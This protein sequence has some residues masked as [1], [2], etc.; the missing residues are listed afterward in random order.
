[1]AGFTGKKLLL[2]GFVIVLLIVIPLT[3]Y[4][5]QQQQKTRIGAA[6]STT[7]SLTPATV[8]TTAGQTF[9][10][11]INMNPGTNQV[12]FVKFVVNYDQTKL[13][14]GSAGFTANS[15]AFPSVL[16]GPIYEPGKISATLSV[17]ASPQNIIQ[18][19]TKVGTI[20]FRALSS[21]TTPTRVSFDTTQTQVLSIASADQFNENVLSSSSP[22]DITITGTA[23]SAPPTGGATNQ[24]PVCSALNTDKATTGAAPYALTFTAVGND[25]DGTVSKVTFN[26]GEGS[27]EDV[28]STGGIG[29]NTVS[30]SKSHTYN[31]AGTYTAVA[32]LTDNL[33]AVSV[34]TNC[35]KTISVTSPSSS[36]TGSS[37]GTGSTG[38]GT[39]T[40][41]GTGSGTIVT[42]ATPSATTPAV[43]GPDLTELPAAGPADLLV[44]LGG[45]AAF[46]AALAIVLL[47]IL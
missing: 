43:G 30:V 13:A 22:S 12:S 20:S 2:L 5:V 6:P 36:G 37:T 38:I 32:T 29:T 24:S 44:K 41:T 19:A 14:T 10:L 4:L 28:T 17:G 9:S 25:P 23:P 18:S 42:V 33:G 35:T 16:Q 45:I 7:M 27:L 40:G 8:S 46:F 39:G 47:V 3:V 34:A 21:T 15:G 11:D 1:M 31:T 26:Y